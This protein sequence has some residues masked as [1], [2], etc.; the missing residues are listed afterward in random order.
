[1]NLQL[2]LLHGSA[3]NPT[4]WIKLFFLLQ[5]LGRNLV[6]QS[7]RCKGLVRVTTQLCSA[8]NGIR[9]STLITF[10]HY[11][12]VLLQG[13]PFYS[14]SDP[15]HAPELGCTDS[16]ELGFP[17]PT[18][19]NKQQNPASTEAQALLASRNQ[20]CHL[21]PLALLFSTPAFSDHYIWKTHFAIYCNL[22]QKK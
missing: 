7:D 20:R 6:L 11:T 1:M 18:T 4:L 14:G 2:D 22:L 9:R 8:K 16:K 5:I 15:G 19:S 12:T 17:T 13:I 3:L 10:F 21:H